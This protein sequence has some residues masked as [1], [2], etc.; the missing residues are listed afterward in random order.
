MQA[1]GQEG[2]SHL[3]PPQEALGPAAA[4]G[5][6]DSA[7]VGPQSPCTLSQGH[8][9]A[10]ASS[11]TRGFA[12][13]FGHARHRVTSKHPISEEVAEMKPVPEP[14]SSLMR[15]SA[16]LANSQFRGR[17]CMALGQEE[18]GQRQTPAAPRRGLGWAGAHLGVTQI[19][20]A[21]GKNR[22]FWEGNHLFLILTERSTVNPTT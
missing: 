4:L 5:K 3:G 11:E 16:L 15:V 7:S 6:A 12:Q 13:V 19:S 9:E 21:W 18:P 17:R 22:L 8:G 20:G 2:L 14:T 1:P 10:G